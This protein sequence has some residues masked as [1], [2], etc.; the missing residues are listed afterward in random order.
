VTPMIHTEKHVLLTEGGF[1][2]FNVTEK[3]RAAVK[4]AGIRDGSS[5]TPTQPGL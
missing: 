4:T 3:A 5:I 1:Q 2:A